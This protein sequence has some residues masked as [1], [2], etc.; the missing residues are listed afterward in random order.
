MTDHVLD[1]A[2]AT[3]KYICCRR[4][5]PNRRYTAAAAPLRAGFS[6]FRRKYSTDGT[7]VRTFTPCIFELF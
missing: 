7:F 2:R 6:Y 5:R 3:L 4:Y 1:I